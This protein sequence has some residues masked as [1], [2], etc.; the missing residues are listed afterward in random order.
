[1][2][3]RSIARLAL[4]SVLAVAALALTAHRM[5]TAADHFDPPLRT[6]TDT[7]T[8]NLD[9]AA[10]IADLYA[11][12][13]ATNVYLA[14]GFGGPSALNLPA[15]YDRDVLYT[16]NVSNS[17]ARTAWQ[18]DD[19]RAGRAQPDGSKW[20]RRSRRAVRRSL[21]LR[22]A[23]AARDPRDRQSR[24]QQPAQPLR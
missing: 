11:F 18:H 7:S 10:D 13:D 5:S 12:H 22:S 14:I 1:M 24:L 19:R 9:V 16:I 15:F 23:G 6:G 3:G 21:L 20:H 4:P 8:A 2:N 17:G